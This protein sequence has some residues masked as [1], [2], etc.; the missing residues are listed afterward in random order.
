MLRILFLILFLCGLTI[1]SVSLEYRASAAGAA[2]EFPLRAICVPDVKPPDCEI[3][4]CE[5]L[6]PVRRSCEHASRAYLMKTGVRSPQLMCFVDV[7]MDPLN[8]VSRVS[9]LDIM[10]AM[11]R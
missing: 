10:R 5:V 8:T 1:V 7:K 2:C 11:S 4:D 6:P 3:P 9:T